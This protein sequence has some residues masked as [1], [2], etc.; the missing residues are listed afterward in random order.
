MPNVRL[1]SESDLPLYARIGAEAYPGVQMTPD[2]WLEGYQRNFAQEHVHF[3]GVFEDDVLLGAYQHYDFL[4]TVRDRPVTVSGIG[5]VAV[6]LLHR[7]RRAAYHLLLNYVRDSRQNAQ[8][9]T[10]LYPFRPDFYRKMGYGYGTIQNQFRIAPAGL[11]RA[12]TDHVR[13][14]EKADQADLLDCYNRYAVA[15]NGMVRRRLTDFNRY[16]DAVDQQILVYRSDA[17][18]AVQGYLIYKFLTTPGNFLANDLLVVEMVYNDAAAMRELLGFLHLLAD[19]IGR[20]VVNTQDEYFH[21]LLTDP[22]NGSGNTVNLYHEASAQGLGLM[23]RVVDVPGLFAA[24]KGHNF[25]GQSVRLRLAIADD[26]LPENA[27]DT[28]L[29]VANGHAEVVPGGAWDVTLGLHVRDFSSLIVGAVSL[30]WLTRNGLATTDKPE[31][32]PVL[33]RLFAW[34]QKPICLTRF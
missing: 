18:N 5:G 26:F 6:G 4:M 20:V 11:P 17:G 30:A 14:A 1:L 22:R 29:H 13:Y 9:L 24:L 23:A 12:G 31:V 8:P 27:G 2:Q 10:W 25:N 16:F 3:W 21:L 28:V 32:L 15:T 33:D 19:Q 34:A 7:K